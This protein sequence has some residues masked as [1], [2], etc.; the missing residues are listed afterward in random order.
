[1]SLYQHP[2]HSQS[3]R[4]AHKLS[5]SVTLSAFEEISELNAEG[6]FLETSYRQTKY[7]LKSSKLDGGNNVS[8]PMNIAK[9][10][11]YA[12]N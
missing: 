3:Y 11:L 5:I 4:S 12:K 9:I 10:I 1:M 6:Q 8:V 2:A 7:G